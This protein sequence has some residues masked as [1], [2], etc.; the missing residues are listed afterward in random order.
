MKKSDVI[1][2]IRGLKQ[3]LTYFL[4][5]LLP[6]QGVEPKAC[7]ALLSQVEDIVDDYV[8]RSKEDIYKCYPAAFSKKFS[9]L[10]LDGENHRQLVKFLDGESHRQLVK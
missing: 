4:G 10:V 3:D 2:D 7:K 5:G 8:G 1:F 9:K 6:V